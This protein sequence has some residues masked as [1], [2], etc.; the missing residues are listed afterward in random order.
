MQRGVW[1]WGELVGALWSSEA[2]HL[3][4]SENCI[5]F[6]ANFSMRT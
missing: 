2:E 1:V 6:P 4:F 5:D 3:E